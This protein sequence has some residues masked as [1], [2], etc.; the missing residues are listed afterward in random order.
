MR[1]SY[2]AVAATVAREGRNK[3]L[4]SPDTTAT[5]FPMTTV[6]QNETHLTP[7]SLHLYPTLISFLVTR[8][9]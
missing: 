8:P 4:L 9:A 3:G 7:Y 5:I 6:P 1:I 2:Q